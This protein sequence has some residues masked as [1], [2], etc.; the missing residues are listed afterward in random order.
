[1]E[2]RIGAPQPAG[3]A[4][5]DKAAGGE[6]GGEAMAIVDAASRAGAETQAWGSAETQAGEDE[7]ES[8]AAARAGAG[9]VG[10]VGHRAARGLLS[11]ETSE[12]VTG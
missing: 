11:K 5:R 12:D 6:G 1:M 9:R 4:S 10:Q 3:E 7:P 2:A 8:E